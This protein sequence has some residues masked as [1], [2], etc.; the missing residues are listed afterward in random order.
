MRNNLPVL[1]RINYSVLL[2]GELEEI[3]YIP[4]FPDG[5]YRAI[6]IKLARINQPVMEVAI[7]VNYFRTKGGERIFGPPGPSY[8]KP[9][10]LIVFTKSDHIVIV[11]CKEHHAEIDIL[12][13]KATILLE[14]RKASIQIK[15]IELFK[16]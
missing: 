16:E 14:G 3:E 10:D 13:D 6:E 11:S 1:I 15:T 2:L 9:T 7:G 8:N 12:D 5:Y 4:I